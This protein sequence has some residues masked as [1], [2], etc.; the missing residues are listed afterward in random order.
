M[1]KMM[2]SAIL[3]LLVSGFLWSSSNSTAQ[4]VIVTGDW[5][6][7]IG[8]ADMQGSP[9]SDLNTSYFSSTQQVAIEI[10]AEKFKKDWHVTVERTSWIS[11]IMLSVRRQ[12]DTRVSGGLSYI[13]VPD[14][15]SVPF[16][17]SVN[18]KDIQNPPIYVQFQLSNVS[19]PE[20][21]ET[22]YT[23]TVTYTLIEGQ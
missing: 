14:V 22:I 20:V 19:V 13:E 10:N 2:Y 21:E 5:S 18:K 11:N 23:T 6:L 9:G 4:T 8:E 3:F 12:A 7:T 17:F 16:F 15:G 1:T